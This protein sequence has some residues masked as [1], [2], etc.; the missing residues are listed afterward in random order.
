MSLASPAPLNVSSQAIEHLDV[1][2]AINDLLVKANLTPE[3][4]AEAMDN[5]VSARTIYRWGKGE[6]QPQQKADI[7]SLSRV[8][9]KYAD[10][11]QAHELTR[12]Q[13][14]EDLLGPVL[15]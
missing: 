7:I 6:H 8:I 3:L 15:D 2:K 9:S 10:L 1:Q 14:N 12:E 5:R 13:T 11:I 4:I